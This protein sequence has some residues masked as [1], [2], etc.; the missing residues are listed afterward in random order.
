MASAAQ[1]DCHKSTN[2][3]IDMKEKPMTKLF[4]KTVIRTAEWMLRKAR[5]L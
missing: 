4:W 2:D 1:Q 5:A 3:D